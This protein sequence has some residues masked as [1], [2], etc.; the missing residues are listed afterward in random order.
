M[1]L[2]EVTPYLDSLLFQGYLLNSN[3]FGSWSNNF[4]V[5]LHNPGGY[6]YNCPLM[7]EIAN[8]TLSCVFD[9][10]NGTFVAQLADFYY[11]VSSWMKMAFGWDNQGADFSISQYNALVGPLVVFSSKIIESSQHLLSL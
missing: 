5:Y 8:Q 1:D 3:V 4:N 11:N 6:K 7:E 10:D 9:M 2:G